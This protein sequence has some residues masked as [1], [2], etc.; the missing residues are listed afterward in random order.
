[1]IKE[2][3]LTPVLFFVCS[4]ELREQITVLREQPDSRETV[5]IQPGVTAEEVDVDTIEIDIWWPHAS[6][7]WDVDGG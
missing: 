6:P 4:L 5:Q 1:M 2:S 7:F 3:F